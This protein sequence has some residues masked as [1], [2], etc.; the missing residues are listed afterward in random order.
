MQR[1]IIDPQGLRQSGERTRLIIM[2]ASET[3]D[4]ETSGQ[5]NRSVDEACQSSQQ[6]DVSDGESVERSAAGGSAQSL[7]P[8]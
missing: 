5:M 6:V 1:N 2:R 4:D 3:V 7:S 8:E